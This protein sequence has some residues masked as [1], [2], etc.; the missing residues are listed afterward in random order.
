MRHRPQVITIF[1]H[2]GGV[3]KTTLTMNIAFA[4]G[5]IGKR[6]L[7]IDSDPQCNLTSYLFEDDVING[8]LDKSDTDQ[9][10]T[11]WTALRGLYH[12]TGDL[13]VVP[14]FDLDR[15]FILPGDI[16]LSKFEM[17]LSR[18]WTECLERQMRGFL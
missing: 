8:F 2:K 1:N 17:L 5:E 13:R 11:I 14:P 12:G 4:L 16:R 10:E 18:A 6:V 7:L 15:L 9:G 3:G